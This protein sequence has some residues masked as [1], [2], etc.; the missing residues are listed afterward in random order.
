MIRLLIKDNQGKEFAQSFKTKEQA[1]SAEI[2]AR[3]MGCTTKIMTNS[4]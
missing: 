4:K 2:L 3:A 1:E